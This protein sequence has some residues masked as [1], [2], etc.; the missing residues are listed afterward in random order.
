MNGQP[1]RETGTS[2]YDGRSDGIFHKQVVPFSQN[3]Q[4]SY[5]GEHLSTAHQEFPHV[6]GFLV[7]IATIACRSRFMLRFGWHRSPCAGAAGY[8]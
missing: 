3:G 1:P 4:P 5:S 6:S 2:S 8:M 7:H